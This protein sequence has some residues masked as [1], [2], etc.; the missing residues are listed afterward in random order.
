MKYNQSDPTGQH[1]TQ[2]STKT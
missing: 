2:N 1:N